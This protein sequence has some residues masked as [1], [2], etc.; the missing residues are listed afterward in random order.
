VQPPDFNSISVIKDAEEEEHTFIAFGYPSASYANPN[1]THFYMLQN[2]L[3][4][5]KT[6]CKGFGSFF[7]NA[8]DI[9]GLFEHNCYLATYP[10]CG[11][12]IQVME[13]SPESA[14][15]VG[16]AVLKSM[17]KLGKEV[18]PE[19]LERAKSM[20]FNSL[21]QKEGVA[22]ISQRNANQIR[23]FNRKINKSE[24]A[25]KIVGLKPED[26]VKEISEWVNSIYPTIA[27]YGKIP[28]DDLIEEFYQNAE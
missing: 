24:F 4:R 20:F 25:S 8:I 21:M 2:L 13:C 23:C 18:K 11:L 14:V 12:M 26:L 7:Q 27:V 1:L 19:E 6:P 10:E 17:E 16:G 5:A 22:E 9:K 3:T 15:F 28:S